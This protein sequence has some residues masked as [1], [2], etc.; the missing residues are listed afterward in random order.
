MCI[1]SS[2]VIHLRESEPGDTRRRPGSR[3]KPQKNCGYFMSRYLLQDDEVRTSA[4]GRD[5]LPQTQQRASGYSDK[6]AAP[7]PIE[8]IYAGYRGL[9]QEG[10]AQLPEDKVSDWRGV[11]SHAELENVSS[12]AR[13]VVPRPPHRSFHSGTAA[14]SARGSEAP[15][16][17]PVALLC[18]TT[19]PRPMSAV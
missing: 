2:T 7:C 13:Q 19:L 12:R 9:L 18:I 5:S 6:T 17:T 10:S 1:S 14:P 4:T 15:K 16:F 11:D 3:R 8:K